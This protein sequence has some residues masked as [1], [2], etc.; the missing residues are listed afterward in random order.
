MRIFTFFLLS[1]FFLTPAFA[2]NLQQKQILL[3][4]AAR[5]DVEYKAKKAVAESLA[6]E[7]DIPIKFTDSDGSYFELQWFENG[8]PIYYITDNAN[9][10][11]TI[12]TN[13]IYIDQIAGFALS[14]A[15]QTLGVWDGGA[16]RLTHQE[17]G[18]RVVQKDGAV[19]TSDHAT[20][21]SGTMIAAGVT[22]SAKGMSYAAN[23]DAYDFNNDYSEILTASANGLKVSNHSYGQIVGWRNNYR[24]DNKWAWLGNTAINPA[25]DYRFGFYDSQSSNWDQLLVNA[26]NLVVCKSAGNDRGEGP[27]P[28]TEHWAI[29]NGT[30]TLN[31]QVRE[32]D[33]GST[34][35]DCVGDGRSIAKNTL[36]VGAVRSVPNYTGPQSV[37]MTTFS[38]WGPTDDGR[39]KPDLV[40]QG[41]SLSSATNTSNT[42]YTT[43]SGTSMSTPSV[44]GS[45]GIVLE[46]QQ[47]LY[48][49]PFRSSTIKA[50]LLHTTDEAGNSEG[51]DYT[52]GWGLMN[53][54]KAVKH[55]YLNAELQNSPLIKE[56]NLLQGA[57]YEY[58][59]MSNGQ[60]PLK[61]TIA[62][63]DPAATPGSPEL[64]NRTPKL[65]NDLDLRIEGP[66][67]IHLPWILDPENPANAAA[68]GDNFRDNVEQVL[69]ASPAAGTYTIKVTHKGTLTTAQ[70]NFSIIVDGII[71]SAPAV[72]NLVS[73]LNNATGITTLPT[74]KWERSSASYKHHL[75]VSTSSAFTTLLVD[76]V[77]SGVFHTITAN[78]P[79]EQTIY[80]RVRGVNS[81]GAGS[82]SP[83]YQFGTTLAIPGQ[84]LLVTPA[85]NAFNIVNNPTL[86]WDSNSSVSS[87]HLQVGNN[88]IFTN[89]HLQDSTLTDTSYQLTNLP[90]NKKYFWRVRA[91]N[92]SGTGNYSNVYNFT[93]AVKA[94]DNLTGSFDN[95]NHIKLDWDDNSSV[96]TRY[97]ILRRVNQ[98]QFLQIDSLAPNSVT[99]TDASVMI[100]NSYTYRV[101]CGVNSIF[102]DSA[103]V[104]V[105]PLVSAESPALLPDQFSLSQNYPNPFN[106]STV[107]RYA[108]PSE[109]FVKLSVFNS[110]GEVVAELQNS[111]K[112]AGYHEVSFDA[113][114]LSSGIYFYSIEVASSNQNEGFKQVRKMLL[115]K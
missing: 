5:A 53:T 4:E 110:I 112:S 28:G 90:E 56:I 65:V 11:Q 49:S 36:T 63:I 54:F 27:A 74:L 88:S 23:L 51:P 91:K 15:G 93:T 68:K 8:L 12:S 7:L 84:P 9:S 13:K 40:A 81:G 38:G 78:L 71:I 42:A 10:S 104:V 6:V 21:V 44:S 19:T 22:P 43:M 83:V 46:A 77:I 103:E 31:T 82:W 35:F 20:H 85:N 67:G 64:N 80:W 109:S 105:T 48:P 99:Y 41:Q 111:M 34:G 58:Q 72:V 55:L 96:E 24:N 114:S 92:N 14:G 97:Y 50:L 76:S 107:I 45:V 102:S 87:Y 25:T 113:S 29:I 69:I 32:V 108:L 59:V 70:Q 26:P 62:W 101:F 75:Q 95:N 94:P 57:S 52:F 18:S 106:P 66:G 2:Q 79:S 47:A 1:C 30:W 37:G 39:I 89:L 3:N 61:V 60:Q 16:V 98:D 86:V 115:V 17:F 33:G 73:P 100:G